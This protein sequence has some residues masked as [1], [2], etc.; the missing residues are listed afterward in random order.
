ME[1]FRAGSVA[2]AIWE[3]EITV[4]GRP[5]KIL[6]AQLSRRYKDRNGYWKSTQ[7]LSRSEIPL[8]IYVLG[9]A[10]AA[11]LEKHAGEDEDGGMAAEEK[12]I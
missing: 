12:V 11:M 8:A 6:K 2:C 9:K 5:Q 1:R 4:D 10:F 7:S 3:N